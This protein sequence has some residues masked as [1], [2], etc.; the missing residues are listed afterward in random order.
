MRAVRR[1]ERLAL[2][3]KRDDIGAGA[4]NRVT[5]LI[6]LLHA[7]FS[8]PTWISGGGFPR[9]KFEMKAVLKESRRYDESL[10]GGS[11]EILNF[12]L[13]CYSALMPASANVINRSKTSSGCQCLAVVYRARMYFCRVRKV[14]IKLSMNSNRHW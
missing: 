9:W 11:N 14:T 1:G 4:G 8:T 7:K 2:A 13:N 5:R 12:E 6:V 10:D 3:L